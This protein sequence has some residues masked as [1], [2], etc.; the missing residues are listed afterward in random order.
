MNPRKQIVRY[1][2]SKWRI[3]PWIASHHP[4]HYC[5]V[6]GCGGGANDIFTKHPSKLEV[7]NDLSLGVVTFFKVLRERPD[8]LIR[9][10][11]F[12]PYARY[13]ADIANQA[14][15]NKWEGLDELEIAR[16]FYVRGKQTRSGNTS[17]W[18]SSFRGEYKPTR[19]RHYIED[20][21]DVD[22]IWAAA[23]RLKKV[24]IENM[25]VLKLIK[26]YDAPTTLFYIDPPYPLDTRSTNWCNAY[27]FE[28][29]DDKHRKLAEM[30]NK[31][32]GMAIISSYP[33]DLYEE[34]FTEQGWRMET[35][36]TRDNQ[37]NYRIEAIW[38]NPLTQKQCIQMSLV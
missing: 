27:E 20:W 38:L 21:Q 8:E 7:Y 33:N 36:R 30:L 32:K 17:A 13:E 5:Y 19:D 3:G 2:G 15:K 14:V 34:L 22:H 9:A 26:K 37:N 35:V 29:G 1:Y 24:Q 4:P 10:I 28:W 6:S 31:I 23:E 11:Q 25:D 16:L 12:T 18:N